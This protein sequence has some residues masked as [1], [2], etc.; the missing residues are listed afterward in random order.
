MREH[1]GQI[2]DEAIR[3][4]HAAARV[5]GDC[6]NQL[7]AR[8]GREIALEEEGLVGL[9]NVGSSPLAGF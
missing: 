9:R 1:L 2:A 3:D 5:G 6:A 8:L 7:E 4:V